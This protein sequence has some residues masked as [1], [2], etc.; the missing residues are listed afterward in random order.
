MLQC[1]SNSMG[2]PAS[3]ANAVLLSGVRAEITERHQAERNKVYQIYM[4][5]ERAGPKFEVGSHP[6]DSQ[7]A[8]LAVGCVK[9]DGYWGGCSQLALFDR[10]VF[11]RLGTRIDLARSGDALFRISDQFLPL[12][13]PAG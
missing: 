3:L 9:G 12:R 13:K 7:Y 1:G 4:I 6:I 8:R 11:S 5:G 10:D 2:T